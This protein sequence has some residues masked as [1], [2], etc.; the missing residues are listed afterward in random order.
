[1]AWQRKIPFGYQVQN[2]RINC[3][4]EEAELVRAS[5]LICF[6]DGTEITQAMQRRQAA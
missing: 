1:M 2:G 4:P 5:L 3:H 6:K